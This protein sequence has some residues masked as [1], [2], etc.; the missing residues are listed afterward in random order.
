M[1]SHSTAN[2]LLYRVDLGVGPT[3]WSDA[4]IAS[5]AADTPGSIKDNSSFVFRR[6][7]LVVASGDLFAASTGNGFKRMSF[8]SNVY[9]D[10]S[11]PATNLGGFPCNP[12][13]PR[14]YVSSPKCL[15]ADPD[16]AT[17]S[18]ASV[19]SKTGIASVGFNTTG[20]FNL[21]H[22]SGCSLSLSILLCMYS[23]RSRC[24]S[25]ND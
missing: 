4:G 15:V 7:I 16:R 10:M 9:Y 23:R 13:T 22:R 5:G 12:Q 14:D 19:T 17:G 11:Q 1:C 8:D 25:S 20:H 24:T 18:V 21:R 2:N 3:N 6:N